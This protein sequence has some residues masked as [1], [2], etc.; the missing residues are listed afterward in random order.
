MEQIQVEG[1]SALPMPETP[2]VSLAVKLSAMSNANND[3]LV[4]VI[5][6]IV[7]ASVADKAQAKAF[8]DLLRRELYNSARDRVSLIHSIVGRAEVESFREFPTFE[9]QATQPHPDS[10]DFTNR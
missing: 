6:T 1:A 9:E 2:G 3:H 7:E 8:K 4:G 10:Y 5:C